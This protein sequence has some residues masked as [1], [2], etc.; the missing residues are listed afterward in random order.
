MPQDDPASPLVYMPSRLRLLLWLV[1]YTFALASVILVTVLLASH[2]NSMNGVLL[3]IFLFG[4]VLVLVVISV[5]CVA[6][7]YRMLRRFPSLIIGADGIVDNSSLIYRGV[8]FIPWKKIQ[9][10][11][12]QEGRLNLGRTGLYQQVLVI[13]P[14]TLWQ[15]ELL[16]LSIQ[17]QHPIVRMIIPTIP[18]ELGIGIPR[19]MLPD[20]PTVIRQEMS[21]AYRQWYPN[22]PRYIRFD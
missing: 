8:G 3:V 20:D 11:T 2:P 9:T 16:P 4:A 1:G 7:L 19:F 6:I 14:T 17:F 5:A 10:V 21:D 13:K 15:L 12:V 22:R 18:I